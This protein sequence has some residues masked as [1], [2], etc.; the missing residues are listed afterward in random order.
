M[1][2]NA[3]KHFNILTISFEFSTK[4]YLDLPSIKFNIF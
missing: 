3:A 4:L 1:I 2:G